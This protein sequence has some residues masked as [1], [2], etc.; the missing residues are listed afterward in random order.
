MATKSN[1]S[2]T[3]VVML[4]IS[5]E[6]FKQQLTNRISIGEELYSR[7]IQNQ[8]DFAKELKN[9]GYSIDLNNLM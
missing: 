6:E 2:Q 5:N 3:R 8:N 1:Q 4:T 9:S 7:Q